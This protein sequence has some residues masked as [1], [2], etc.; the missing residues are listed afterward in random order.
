MMFRGKKFSRKL[1]A[2]IFS[3]KL[4]P[5]CCIG[6]F[7]TSPL[8]LPTLTN[9]KSIELQAENNTAENY[10][11]HPM[12]IKMLDELE[13]EHDFDRL[14]IIELFQSVKRQDAILEAMSRP[15]EKTKTWSEYKPIFVNSTGVKKGL[16]FWQKHQATFE[17]A[18]EQ[19]Q[20][21]EAIL[22]AI[23]GVE[24]R[25]G[26][27]MGRHKI[28]ESL[29]TLAFDYPPRSAFFLQRTETLS[30]FNKAAGLG[31]SHH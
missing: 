23:I 29:A 30:R 16:A 11:S 24:T 19:F 27:Y 14:K 22:V 20:V 28:I 13:K 12:F 2:K 25:Y 17:K 18:A 31:S 7:L 9:A 1:I 3:V 21:P 26:T 10:I 15:A 8:V 5:F 4:I 6:S